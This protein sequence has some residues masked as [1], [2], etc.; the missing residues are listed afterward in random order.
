MATADQQF[1]LG[2]LVGGVV[3]VATI[4]YLRFCGSVSLA[5]KPPPPRGPTRTETQLLSQ[6][7]ASPEVYRRYLETDASA[8]GVRAPTIE[9]MSRKFAYRVDEARHVLE[10]GQPP[11]D[12]AGVR[13]HLERSNEGLVMVIQNLIASDLAYEVSSTPSTGS[14]I[15]NSARPL[16]FN[17]NVLAKGASETRI[18]CAWRDGESVAVTKVETMEI[19]PLSNWYLSQVPPQLLGVEDRLA[20]GH[21]GA[22]GKEK[23]SQV[24]SQVVRSGIDRGD[25]GWRD[26]ADFYARHR[27]QTYSFPSRYR[28]F[29]SDDERAIPAVEGAH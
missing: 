27:C 4:T 8:A 16:P 29:K 17:A 1:R 28:A 26:L 24:M 6:S 13:L 11:I 2:V 21:H 19:S 3:L 10:P 9:E 20:R 12:I 7:T 25:I 14:V 5:P 15:C 22:E 18:E 23:C